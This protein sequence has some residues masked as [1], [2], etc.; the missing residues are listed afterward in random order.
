M[1]RLTCLIA[2]SVATALLLVSTSAAAPPTRIPFE[3]DV[4]FPSFFTSLCGVPVFLHVEGGGTTTLFYD[5]D[6]NVIRELDTA[7][8]GIQFTLF[9]PTEAEPGSHS[10]SPNT[11]RLRTDIRRERTSA[12]PRSRP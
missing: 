1:R 5:Q 9:S 10:A 12:T 2:S 11:E 8:G 4:T 6:G 7:P 3:V